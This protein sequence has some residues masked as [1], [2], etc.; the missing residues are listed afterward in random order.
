MLF[1]LGTAACTQIAAAAPTP[2]VTPPA[3]SAAPLAALKTVAPPSLE[4]VAASKP[5][6]VAPLSPTAPT[7][8]QIA[9]INAQ[10]E[11]QE[12]MNKLNEAR[13][14]AADASKPAAVIAPTG[15]TNTPKPPKA[16]LPPLAG[17]ST[18][19]DV[20][21]TAVY[22]VGDN[23]FADVKYGD[24]STTVS[25]RDNPRL[26][27]W[28]VVKLTAHELTLRQEKAPGKG[29]KN[30]P[31]ATTRV[32]PIPDMGRMTNESVG[33]GMAAPDF[34]G[35]PQQIGQRSSPTMMTSMPALPIP[36]PA[37]PQREE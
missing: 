37:P 3:P 28:T 12:V 7:F 10:W 26:G 5:A 22:G 1:V 14:K 4:A 30:N 36:M 35:V 11:Y 17:L 20:R 9:D 25:V 33:A 32:I 24:L 21:V 18:P 15:G 2:A 16:F 13:A 34:T 31:A 19:S 6:S 27:P 29:K 8:G 23:L